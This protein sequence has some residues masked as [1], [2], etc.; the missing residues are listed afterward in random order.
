MPKTASV[1]SPL[2][3]LSRPYAPIFVADANN[4][5]IISTHLSYEI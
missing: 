4:E 5:A 1:Y 3:R 2:Y